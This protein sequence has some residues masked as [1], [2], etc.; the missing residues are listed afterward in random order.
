MTIQIFVYK[1][2]KL[3]WK[4]GRKEWLKWS[5]D[6]EV[7]YKNKNKNKYK[8]LYFVSSDLCCQHYLHTTKLQLITI[9]GHDYLINYFKNMKAPHAQYVYICV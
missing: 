3:K 2:S 5:T 7:Q 6:A 4:V 9:K 8:Y 1:C